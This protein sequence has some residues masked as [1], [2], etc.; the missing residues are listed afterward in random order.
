MIRD[1]VTHFSLSLLVG[2]LIGFF[3][4]NYSAIYVA[5]LSGVLI[6]IDHIVDFLMFNKLKKINMEMLMSGKYFIKNK[7]I[8]LFFH[9]YE[10]VLIT[11]VLGFIFTEW[12]WLYFSFSFS[13]LCHLLYD[14]FYNRTRW[15]SYFILYRLY[16]GFN[17]KAV[18]NN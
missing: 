9:G 16:K 4:Q 13:L 14:S 5:F 3:Y 18:C 6:D 17:I 15:F 1:E 7:K 2:I 12:Q 11:I 8:Y 10:Y